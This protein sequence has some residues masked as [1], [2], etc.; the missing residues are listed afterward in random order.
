[1]TTLPERVAALE[2]RTAEKPKSIVD[3]I[4]DWGGV[5]SLVIAVG[6]S[7]PLG[8]WEKFVEPENKRVAAELQNLRNVI[9]ETT[10]IFSEGAKT[11]AAIQDPALYDLAGRAVNTRI[12][13]LMNKH[14]PRFEQYKA[15][16]TA[17]ELLVVGNN[18]IM[19]N[20]PEV[21]L[22]FFDAARDS[23]GQDIQSRVE[24][25]RQ[26]AK[27]RFGPGPLQDRDKAR[28]NFDA[29][30]SMMRPIRTMKYAATSLLSEWA[31]FE[32]LDGDWACGQQK[33]AAAK[34]A[35]TEL[36]PYLNDNGNF[37][38]L[39]DQKTQSLVRQPG[40]PAAGC[41]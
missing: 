27:I 1:M 8:I 26:Q 25:L 40:Q 23:A 30:I 41:Q 13:L 11:L 22:P 33:L 28:K 14:R 24:A 6:Y 39:V 32:L 15:E 35:L 2:E 36:S 31:L 21:A 3:R 34:L 10:T 5:A 12:F 38:R 19:T 4:K 16:L 17:P 7:F 20:Q 9:E 29:A 18:F 37:A